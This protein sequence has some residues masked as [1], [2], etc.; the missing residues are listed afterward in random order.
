MPNSNTT[1]T[2]K[3]KVEEFWQWYTDISDD[4][5]E[6]FE[7]GGFPDIHQHF[8]GKLEE[9]MPKFAWV[10]GPGPSDIGGHSFTL[11]AG[12]EPNHQFLTEYWKSRA[13]E[14]KGWTFHASRQP[15]NLTPE[16][17]FEIA[18]MKYCFVD[19]FISTQVDEESERVNI[20]F[21]AQPLADAEDNL[22]HHVMF[23]MLD[24]VLGEY[25]TGQWINDLEFTQAKP[26][27]AISILK[28]R[29]VLHD[30]E[31]QHGWE[32]LPPTESGS[33]YEVPEV[34]E[35]FARSDT[36]FGSTVNFSLIAE[37]L[38]SQGETPDLLEGSGADFV[39]VSFD[40]SLLPDG[41][42]V[43]YR[44]NI[45]DQI[46]ALLEAEFVGVHLG[47]AF[48]AINSYIDFLLF[49]TARGMEI[50]ETSLRQQELPVGTSIEFFAKSKRAQ[51]VV[52]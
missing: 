27:D 14:L 30:L 2:F 3:A 28:L 48:G 43:D 13:P 19:A 34:A 5:Y 33:V 24:E 38:D 10:F 35:S 39:Y 47:G 31:L 4:L 7:T 36:L 1:K 37:H 32:K 11:S 21:F 25:G 49:D 44:A 45:A 8:A 42:Q 17:E 51:S 6:S 29:D 26:D 46:G 9:L 40:S 22:K 18:G 50:I 15:G 41:G 16:M 20:Q 12:G 52:L 23:L